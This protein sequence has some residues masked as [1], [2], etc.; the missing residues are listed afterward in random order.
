MKKKVGK[1]TLDFYSQNEVAV[2]DNVPIPESDS[3]YIAA[4]PFIYAAKLLNNFPPPTGKAP[5]QKAISVLPEVGK[6]NME[7]EVSFL[8][9]CC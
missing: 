6:E 4:F 1:I 8:G 9:M 5:I 7:H 2:T 3:M